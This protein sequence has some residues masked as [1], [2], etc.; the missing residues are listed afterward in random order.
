[1]DA[2][3]KV[4]PFVGIGLYWFSPAAAHSPTPFPPIII[5]DA[6]VSLLLS[7][8]YRKIKRQMAHMSLFTVDNIAETILR[9]I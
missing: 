2:C 5:R 9:R 1:M 4:P 8:V 6:A 7:I 3:R